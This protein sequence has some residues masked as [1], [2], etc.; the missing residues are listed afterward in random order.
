M[1]VSSKLGKSMV[2]DL[3]LEECFGGCGDL[4]L[5]SMGSQMNKSS[6]SLVAMGEVSSSEIFMGSTS[7]EVPLSFLRC[8]QSFWKCLRFSQ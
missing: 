3:S 1:V 8:R 2:D 6:S 7:F 4:S 5:L